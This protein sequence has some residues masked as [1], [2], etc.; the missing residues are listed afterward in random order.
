MKRSL[1]TATLFTLYVTSAYAQSSNCSPYAQTDQPC[2]PPHSQLSALGPVGI[3]EPYPGQSTFVIAAYDTQ[4]IDELVIS[5]ETP[6]VWVIVENDSDRAQVIN[7]MYR[8]QSESNVRPMHKYVTVPS[9]DRI[10]IGLHAERVAYPD[11]T[12]AS[13]P[14]DVTFSA[15]AYLAASGSVHA[16]TSN[17]SAQPNVISAHAQK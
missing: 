16:T 3:I 5:A 12:N 10:A 7:V 1:F 2:P 17:C 11:G 13:F 15:T 8:F 14:H 4:K 6:C 9:Q